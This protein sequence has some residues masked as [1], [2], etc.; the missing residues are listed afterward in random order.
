MNR[1]AEFETKEI[2]KPFPVS[3]LKLKYQI[4]NKGNV[5]NIKKGTKRVF[6]IK[7]GYCKL[8]FYSDN[9]HHSFTIHRMVAKVFVGN[10]DPVNKTW[11][12][13]IDGDTYNNNF[14]NLEWITPKGNSQHAVDTGL[15]KI[16][17]R[18]VGQ[19][20]LD[21]NL[22][23]IYESQAAAAKS[24]RIDRRYINRVCKGNK[25]QTCG[26][27]WK[28]IDNDPNEKIVN[29]NDY[30]QIKKFPNYWIN[31][32]GDVYSTKTKKIRRTKI[33][34]NGTVYIQ[35]TK[36]NPEG[37]QIVIEI[38][39]QNIVAKYY[40]V[41]PKNKK[42]NFVKHIDGDKQNNYFKNLEW[43]YMPSIKHILE[44]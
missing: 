44:I 32:K 17:K 43:C 16:T 18:K 21:G 2:W 11:V 37:G 7:S 39:V 6:D 19:Y 23:K 34:N 29:L 1:L 9:I 10:P 8:N 26:F 14:W 4:S 35:L 28:N 13:H 31:E 3:F 40:L 38:P 12:N 30:K 27:I 41:K 20:D 42:V 33:K 24:T 36:A 15:V 22:I 25:N 5:I